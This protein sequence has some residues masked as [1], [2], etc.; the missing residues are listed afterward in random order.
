M[1]LAGFLAFISGGPESGGVVRPDVGGILRCSGESEACE[2]FATS[3]SSGDT[4]Y[5][6]GLSDYHRRHKGSRVMTELSFR[7]YLETC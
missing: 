7:S 2:E 3:Y 4:G 1:L 6:E 5:F